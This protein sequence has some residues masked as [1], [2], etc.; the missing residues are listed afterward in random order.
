MSMK[1]LICVFLAVSM[2]ATVLASGEA[3]PEWRKR[4]YPNGQ[5]RYEGYFLNG[6]PVGEFKR[7]HENGKLQS[8]QT[9]QDDDRSTVEVYAGD[10]VLVA[11]GAYKGNKREGLWEFYASTGELFLT[12]FYV[13]GLR[14]G[15]SLKYGPKGKEQV[16]DRMNYVDDKLEGERI[17]YYPYGNKMAVYH[18]HNGQLDGAFVSFL[19]SGEKEEEGA[20]KNGK[21][22]GVWTYYDYE[23]TFRQIEYKDGK[24]LNQ[25]ELDEELR[26]KEEEADKNPGLP[27]PQDYMSNPDEILQL[28]P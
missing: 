14:Q 28:M 5:T 10:G 23:G 13:G 24:A 1:K 21:K 16:M 22:D 12:E 27:D 3:R 15:E 20:Y 26:K 6:K 19:D 9:F 8:V 25:K 17:Q 18:Y 4:T 11:K 2:A 7:Y